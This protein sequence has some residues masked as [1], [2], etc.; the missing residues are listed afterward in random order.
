MNYLIHHADNAFNAS[1]QENLS[2][3]VEKQMQ[4]IIQVLSPGSRPY[5][6]DFYFKKEGNDLF[7]I[8]AIVN[9][10]GDII[11]IRERAIELKSS[12]ESIF[13]R[14]KLAIIKQNYRNRKSNTLELK[15]KQLSSLV[16]YMG[17]L[18][19]MK[20]NKAQDVF[21]QMLKNLLK[22][23][24]KYINRRLKAAEMTTAIKRGR[25]KVQELLDE[26]YLMIYERFEEKAAEAEDINTWIFQ[27]ADELLEK[28]LKEV[29]FEKTH[30]KDLES[31]VE[32]EYRYLE[33]GDTFESDEFNKMADYYSADDL[34]IGDDETSLLDDI[35]LRLN[36]KEIHLLIEKELAK[37][38][39]FKRTIMDLY[40][41]NQM[42]IEEIANLKEITSPE[43]DAVIAEVNKD[44]VKKLSVLI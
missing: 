19:E 11:Y 1:E 8:S 2:S 40:L 13:D 39:I 9:L 23:V 17:D 6:V 22:E 28:L 44:L 15:E 26:L 3:L 27:L 36:Q 32:S 31:F 24:A 10:N 29:E 5:A 16:E 18:Q 14:M 30:F 35:T 20:N 37:L 41:I 12:L 21:N 43:V 34:I 33:G 38:P 42:S 25:F 4:R 7:E